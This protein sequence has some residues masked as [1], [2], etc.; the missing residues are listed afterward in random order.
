MYMAADNDL[1]NLYFDRD[2]EAMEEIG[3]TDRVHIVAM[4]DRASTH[5]ANYYYVR[6]GDVEN[7]QE[8]DSVNSGNGQILSH[9][10][11]F[12]EQR[13]PAERYALILWDHGGGWRTLNKGIGED[14]QDQDLIEIPELA[15]ALSQA[16]V[17][18]SLIGIDACRMATIEVAYE[19][20][21]H[22]DIMVA[23]QVDTWY[24]FPYR[25]FLQGLVQN[26]AMDA[27]TLAREIIDNYVAAGADRV[28]S[29]IKLNR[30]EPLAQALSN[31]ATLLMSR[32]GLDRLPL[33]PS[34][35]LQNKDSLW[36]EDIGCYLDIYNYAH[37]TLDNPN[38]AISASSQ[39]IL[40]RLQ[41]AVD[42]LRANGTSERWHHG[43]SV[44]FPT[45]CALWDLCWTQ[46]EE[47]AFSAF[48][49]DELIDFSCAFGPP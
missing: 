32:R 10:I 15:T 34:A 44:Y 36:D 20:R 37:A 45:S 11:R 9:F 25:Q 23:S 49:W 30:V 21:A 1:Y 35:V 29:A 33:S 40:D 43:L 39:S 22:G 4:V 5:R 14:S 16:G 13:Y 26:P 7:L 2:W 46:Y 24:S 3:S 41:E 47:L 19:I 48:R 17:H 31:Y 42:Y 6:R 12:A 28:L 18:F 8:L 27:S 38:P